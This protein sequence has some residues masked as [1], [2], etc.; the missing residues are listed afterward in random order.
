MSYVYS[1]NI[2][3]GGW[4]ALHCALRGTLPVLG[5]QVV[6]GSCQESMCLDEGSVGTGRRVLGGRDGR[7]ESLR[8]LLGERVCH[9]WGKQ[10]SAHCQTVPSRTSRQGGL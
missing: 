9:C 1:D 7:R 4:G 2:G 6:M 8:P 5:V 3:P 10:G